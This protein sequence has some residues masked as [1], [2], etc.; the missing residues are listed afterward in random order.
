MRG[1][2][3]RFDTVT[4]YAESHVSSTI[5]GITVVVHSFR[6]LFPP[7][8]NWRSLATGDSMSTLSSAI[9]SIAQQTTGHSASETTSTSHNYIQTR[10]AL[11]DR[12]T[13]P[14]SGHIAWEK[15]A[16]FRLVIYF[17]LGLYGPLLIF[18]GYWLTNHFKKW[19]AQEACNEEKKQLK[20]RMKKEMKARITCFGV[21]SISLLMFSSC[22]LCDVPKANKSP[23]SLTRKSQLT[24]RR[25]TARERENG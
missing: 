13:I 17:V 5:T 14:V 4:H 24:T 20:M 16:G 2:Y 12:A 8:L 23:T 25:E 3:Q 1:L 18:V 7:N 9:T 6:T 11:P 22:R 10:S 15:D 21:L 19:R